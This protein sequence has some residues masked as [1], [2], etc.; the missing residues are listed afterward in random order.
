MFDQGQQVEHSRPIL[1]GKYG[2]AVVQNGKLMH[3]FWYEPCLCCRS[4][5]HAL[6]KLGCSGASSN[7]KKGP[8]YSF[9]LWKS[10]NI[11]QGRWPALYNIWG[12]EIRLDFGLSWGWWWPS[13]HA[14]WPLLWGFVAGSFA[15]LATTPLDAAKTRIM[16]M[17]A[18]TWS[19]PKDVRIGIATCEAEGD[20]TVN[21][22][23][24]MIFHVHSWVRPSATIGT[25]AFQED[26]RARLGLWR[27]LG[28]MSKDWHDGMMASDG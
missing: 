14:V 15:G 4:Y 6:W 3:F 26:P 21:P 16:L 12:N 11:S 10:W 9:S 19:P 23:R 1:S 13:I 28:V 22:I 24:N 7:P 5:W 8:E 27:T 18:G 20:D 25:L 2:N 17:A